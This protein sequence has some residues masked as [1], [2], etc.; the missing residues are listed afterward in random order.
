M[1]DRP[2]IL[3]V[4]VGYSDDDKD[5]LQFGEIL[6]VLQILVDGYKNIEALL[7]QGHQLTVGDSSP[8]HRLDRLDFVVDECFSDAWIDA[9]V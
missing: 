7:R 6:L 2:E 8:T 3:D 4:V 5:Q 1:K 9:L